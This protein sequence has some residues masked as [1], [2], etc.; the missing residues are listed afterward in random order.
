MRLRRVYEAA[1]EEGR[2]V[3]EIAID[4]F[5]SLQAYEEAKEERRVLDEREGKRGRR[6]TQQ[7]GSQSGAR[8]APG[9]GVRYMFTDDGGSGASSRSAS[10]R[11]PNLDRGSSGPSTPSPAPVMGKRAPGTLRVPS[12]LGTPIPSVMTP[13]ASLAR[14]TTTRTMNK[15]RALSPS[16]L[17]KLQAKVLRAKLMGGADAATLEKEYEDEM[18]RRNG[19]GD[20]SDEERVTTKVEVL[21]SMDG[22]GRLYDTGKGRDDDTRVLP[23]NRKKKEKVCDVAW[24]VSRLLT[25]LSRG[26]D[27]RCEDRRHRPLQRR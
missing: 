23:G 13:P 20:G 8:G 9:S 12:H 11:R 5:G 26:R 22:Q 15:K 7:T 6:D 4:R 16:S 3:E 1:E 10:F 21:P 18:R 14:V 25:S 2:P 19:D 24:L 27:K 17:N